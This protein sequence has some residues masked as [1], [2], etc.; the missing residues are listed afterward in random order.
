MF[1][2]L[3][4]TTRRGMLA[5]LAEGEASV[6]ELAAPLELTLPAV[7]KHLK[8]LE[9]AGLVRQRKDGQY[10]PRTLEPE[11]L[12]AA[13]SWVES[14]RL[15][16]EERLDRMDAHLQRQTTTASRPEEEHDGR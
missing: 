2:A 9:G 15:T 12:A 7:S 4:S 3:A 13:V 5:R 10:R 8:V 6:N 1:A 16:W 14:C 11:P